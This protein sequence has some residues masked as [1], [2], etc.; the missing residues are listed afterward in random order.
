VI[1]DDADPHRSFVHLASVPPDRSD[2][3]GTFEP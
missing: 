2:F 3:R 1:V